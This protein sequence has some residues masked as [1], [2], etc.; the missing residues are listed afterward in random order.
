MGY[1]VIGIGGTGAKCLES[2]IHLAAAGMM[3][4]EDIYVLFV[5]SDTANGSL[6]RAQKTL[7][8][9]MIC[10]DNT[11][12]D[13]TGLLP[14]KLVSPES[15]LWTPC[16]NQGRQNLD[17]SFSYNT[18]R[19]QS[20]SAR[21]LFNVLYSKEERSTSLENGFLG[22]PSIGSAFLAKTVNLGSDEPWRTFGQKIQNDEDPKIFLVGSIFG[23]TGASGFP[24]I[25][26]LVKDEFSRTNVNLR[27]GGAL[28]LP[29]FTFTSNNQNDHTLQA[30]AEHFSMNT[31]AALKY[32]Y[33]WNQTGIYDAVYLFGNEAQNEVASSPGGGAQKNVPHFI[34]LYAALAAMHFFGS[35]VTDQSAQYF[36]IARHEE[37][38]LKWEDLPDGENGNNIR[39]KIG[40]LAR[41]AF[42]Y[43][44]VYQP[45]L[46]E[47]NKKKKSYHVPWFVD[48]FGRDPD[49]IDDND[50]DLLKA[51]E[52]Y[53]KTF[54]LWL[55]NIQE[56]HGQTETNELVEYG[57]YASKGEGDDLSVKPV[58]EFA[59]TGFSGLIQSQEKLDPKALHKLWE[60]M[61]NA[62]RKGENDGTQGIG[63][64]LSALYKNCA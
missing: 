16:G 34:E 25:A 37:N 58:N 19:N 15:N 61:C 21:Y 56:N 36:M 49:G 52:N 51:V 2:I 60:C 35:T 42:A 54:L 1:Y 63:S 43:L 39:S 47:I 50:S 3:P 28:V 55:A 7:R 18:L 6:G 10:K 48:F 53:C 14:T 29:Y 12:L 23:G 5:D 40:Q 8:S 26:K 31:Q 4:V 13:R 11:R 17:D 27:L 41:F 45:T 44:S 32:Y 22:R 57:A 9:Y 33:L 46:Q 59:L 20:E 30:R 62:K 38:L 24:T 64:F